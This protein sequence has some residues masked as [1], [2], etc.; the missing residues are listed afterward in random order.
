MSAIELS[1]AQHL[2][3]I[4]R[5]AS[6]LAL[7]LREAADAGVSHMVI[8]PQLMLCFRDAF[9]AMPPDMAAKLAEMTA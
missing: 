3:R 2:E 6:R 1:Q 5:D 8:L 7:T 4:S 9:G